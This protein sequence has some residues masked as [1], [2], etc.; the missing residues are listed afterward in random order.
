VELKSATT[1]TAYVF[2]RLQRQ[3]GED[4]F[5]RFNEAICRFLSAGVEI[6]DNKLEGTGN[7]IQLV[8]NAESEESRNIRLNNLQEAFF[9]DLQ[10]IKKPILI[11]FDTFNEAPANLANWIGGAFL[12]E[13]AD[14]KNIRVVIAG[15]S[16]PKPTIEWISLSE[17]HCLDAINDIEVWHSFLEANKL[18]FTRETV[19]TVVLMLEGKPSTIIQGLESVVRRLAP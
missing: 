11:V 13:V 18:P 15:Q 12:S 5:T 8:L 10:A 4:K 19:Q 16:V 9:R 17:T 6:A 1:G 3:L 2:S 7:K 14:V